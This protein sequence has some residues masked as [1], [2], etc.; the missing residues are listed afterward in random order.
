ML[1]A[2]DE[3]KALDLLSRLVDHDVTGVAA[4]RHEVIEVEVVLWPIGDN[5]RQQKLTLPLWA[6]EA[7][8]TADH[9]AYCLARRIRGEAGA[10][11]G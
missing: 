2:E 5:Q 10:Y 9:F 6:W 3:R 4:I 8:P 1:C 7:G 11:G